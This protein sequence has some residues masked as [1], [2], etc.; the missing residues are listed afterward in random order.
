[1]QS[2]NLIEV[3]SQSYI[4]ISTKLYSNQYKAISNQY[5]AI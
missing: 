3:T 5:K 4:G 2:N 1:M